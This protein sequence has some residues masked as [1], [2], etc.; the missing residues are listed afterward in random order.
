M[1][2]ICGFYVLFCVY[3][4][5]LTPPPQAMSLADDEHAAHWRRRVQMGV[6]PPSPH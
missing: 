6:N 1:N 4:C 2:T 5:S 3:L